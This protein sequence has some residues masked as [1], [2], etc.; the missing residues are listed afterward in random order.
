MSHDLRFEQALIVEAPPRDVFDCFFAPDALRAW[1]Q[2]VRSVTTP[3]PFGVYA[4]QWATTPFRD[5]LLGAL[6][7]T[8]HGTVIEAE[9]GRR[10][11]VAD[12]W[13]LPPEG[14]PL[15]PMALSVECL[16]HP[17]G[18]ALRV[19]QEGAEPSPRW[20]RYY[21]VITRGWQVSLVALKRYVEAGPVRTVDSP[22]AGDR[23]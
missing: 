9:P 22:G 11:A 13:W 17:D 1:W 21:A 23:R 18:C 3:V 2:A 8:F 5:D 16:P 4:V 7:G 15:G 12:A 19:V 10:F 20:R 14:A 6:G